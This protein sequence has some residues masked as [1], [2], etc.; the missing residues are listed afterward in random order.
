MPRLQFGSLRM[1]K[2][3]K[4]MALFSS[5]SLMQP[6]DGESSPARGESAHGQHADQPAFCHLS[7]L[8]LESS[9]LHAVQVDR[10]N[11]SGVVKVRLHTKDA[12]IVILLSSVRPLQWRISNAKYSNVQRVVLIGRRARV[13]GLTSGT[14]VSHCS[15]EA[16]AQAYSGV[17]IDHVADALAV[18]IESVQ[19]QR[20]L[21]RSGFDI[22]PRSYPNLGDSAW[23]RCRLDAD[24][25]G[26]NI[27]RDNSTDL[28]ACRKMCD[29]VGE[30]NRSSGRTVCVYQAR[31]IKAYA[32]DPRYQ[33]Q[34]C[35]LIASD[36][37][38]IIGTSLQPLSECKRNVCS[39]GKTFI[40]S[41]VK[42]HWSSSCLYNGRLVERFR[43]RRK[44]LPLWAR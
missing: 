13:H 42:D 20:M 8:A 34:P 41:N 44:D 21:R 17:I 14:P 40:S 10:S 4:V 12:P 39:T 36:G 18:S 19:R 16:S 32:A 3:V 35:R 24:F 26:L 37:R 15:I 1:L 31:R 9:T 6:L 29:R 33:R 38:N 11:N 23:D 5:L 30:W 25:G 27:S 22:M 43:F 28:N 2:P 7:N